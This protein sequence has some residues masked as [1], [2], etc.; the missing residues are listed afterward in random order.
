VSSGQDR[1]GYYSDF[2]PITSLAKSYRDAYVYDG[3]YSEHRKRKF[4]MKAEGFPGYQFIVFSQ[5]HDHVGNRMLGER[6]S[7]LVSFE[8]QKLLVGAVFVS[9]FLPLLFMG[10]EF[11]ETNPFQYFVSHTDKELAQA[12]REGRKREFA[13]FHMEGEAPDPVSDATFRQ[14]KLQWDL[15]EKE[16]HR[17]LLDYYKKLIVLKKTHPAL[18]NYDRDALAVDSFEEKQL[19]RVQRVSQGHHVVAILNFSKSPQ[20]ALL[21]S[22]HLVWHK[23]LASSEPEW[24]GMHIIAEQ[25]TPGAITVPPESFTLF[26]NIIDS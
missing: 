18:T 25:H 23:L 8:M 26:G 20:E 21:P 9:P 15:C 24:G 22:E 6:T 17:S 16:P 10:E 3:I 1:T 2:E 7:Q 5:N 14:S 11:G 13:A 19:I 12:V 4:G